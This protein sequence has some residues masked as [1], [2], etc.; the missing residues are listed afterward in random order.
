MKKS[1]KDSAQGSLFGS[2]LA[3]DF[4]AN[5]GQVPEN[6]SA[7]KMLGIS[8]QRC[9][10]SFKSA[11]PTRL[12]A[13]MFLESLVGTGDWSSRRCKLTWRLKGSRYSRLWFQLVPSALPTEGTGFGLLP[14]ETPLMGTPTSNGST[15]SRGKK[16]LGKNK[17][18]TPQEMVSRMNGL[19]PTPDCQN[20][21]DG[22]KLRKDSNMLQGG[23]HATSLHHLGAYDMLPT[24]QSRDWKGA[25]GR[26]YKGEENDLPNMVKNLT[27]GM[28]P[29]PNASDDRDRGGP[30]DRAIQRRMEIGKQVGLTQMVDGQL[31]GRFV[32]EMM[33]FPPD[34]V[35][36]AF[37]ALAESQNP[38]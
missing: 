25:S 38:S 26:S 6:D 11:A 32:L 35:E 28:L 21:R 20:H 17:A 30:K 5:R 29:T 34:W 13:R 9:L 18:P 22:K 15:K 36:S 16:F 7:R 8:G 31:S 24:P 27:N 37:L 10:E 33:G 4:P 23:S 14:I 3:V 19:L 1:K 2:S 12:W